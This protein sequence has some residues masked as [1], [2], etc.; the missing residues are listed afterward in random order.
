MK[1]PQANIVFLRD[2]S[3]P[4]RQIFGNRCIS[5]RC[6][7]RR[8]K[9]TNM[10]ILVLNDSAS[11]ELRGDCPVGHFRLNVNRGSNPFPYIGESQSPTKMG[12]VETYNNR[13]QNLIYIKAR[14]SWFQGRQVFTWHNLYPFSCKILKVSIVSGT[15]FNPESQNHVSTI[16]VRSLIF[17]LDGIC[18]PMLGVLKTCSSKPDVKYD[19]VNHI[20]L[21]P[22]IEGFR[23]HTT[24]GP[25]PLL[26]VP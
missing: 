24:A 1:Y 2:S 11:R 22:V 18:S 20:P 9:L 26:N 16:N 12:M 19:Q 6:H 21:L 15:R 25:S 3:F 5:S 4:C 14:I 13:R 17:I 23:R 7:R 8:S 10:S